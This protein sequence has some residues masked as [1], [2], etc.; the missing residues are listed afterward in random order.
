MAQIKF[1]SADTIRK[2]DCVEKYLKAYLKVMKNQSFD[3]IYVDA[4]AGTGEIP[5]AAEHPGLP[6]DL[7]HFIHEP[8]RNAVM[9]GDEAVGL[10]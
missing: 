8:V 7:A 10:T 5:R 1:G 6:L 9:G 4:F 2:L 3:T